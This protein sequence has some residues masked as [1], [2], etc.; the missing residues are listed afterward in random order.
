MHITIIGAAFSA[1]KGAAS[2]LRAAIHGIRSDEPTARISV[3]TT[4]PEADRA[5]DDLPDVDIV[6]LTPMQL[7]ALTAPAAVSGLLQR[8]TGR[9][10]RLLRRVPATATIMESDAVLDLAGISFVD[11]R[12][13]PTLTYNS[14]MT[15]LAL[16]LRR[17]VV[18]GSQAIGPMER[19]TTRWAARAVL[20]RV[21]T[22][23]ARGAVTR[24]HLDDFGGL[25]AVD[26]PDMAFLL[27]EGE[28]LAVAEPAGESVALVPSEVVRRYYERAGRSYLEFIAEFIEGL[29]SRGYEVLVVPHAIRPNEPASKMNDGP[30]AAEIGAMTGAEVVSGDPSPH[31][32]RSALSACDIVVTSRFHAMVSALA[33]CTPVMVVGWSHK[34]QEV[35]AQFGLE[36]VALDYH[37][38]TA[39]D[40]LAHFDNIALGSETSSKIASRLPEVRRAANRSITAI[41]DAARGS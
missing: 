20:P 12:G 39:T 36:H 16:L 23:C 2:M 21:H 31:Q 7:L 38:L 33:T 6:S 4:Y 32:L 11:G 28:P 5:V 26:A 27:E 14:L 13:I 29:R 41:L 18:K 30:L 17:P 34:Y 1:N 35:L 8:L 37:D 10:G 9:G 25:N 3:L 40:A 15:G 19:V 24:R 22:I